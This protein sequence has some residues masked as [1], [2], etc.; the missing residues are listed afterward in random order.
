MFRQLA[1]QQLALPLGNLLRM[2]IET[3]SELRNGFFAFKGCDGHFS[4]KLG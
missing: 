2:N 1:L 4:I 3:L